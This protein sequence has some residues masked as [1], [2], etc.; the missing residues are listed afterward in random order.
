MIGQTLTCTNTYI[1]KQFKPKQ[2][3]FGA[4]MIQL[5]IRSYYFH[6]QQTL[7]T[8]TLIT[9]K[10]FVSDSFMDQHGINL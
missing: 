3:L 8:Q 7:H 1:T 2:T 4:D 5:Q 9:S 10:K 6:P